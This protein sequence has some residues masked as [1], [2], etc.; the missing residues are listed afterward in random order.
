LDVHVAIEEKLFYAPLRKGAE[1][2]DEL[3]DMYEAYTEHEVARHL[4]ELLR[5]RRTPDEEFKARLQVLGESVKHHVQEEESK[6]FA[7]ARELMDPQERERIGDAWA[8]QKARMES[9][10]TG[11]KKTRAKTSSSK[12][13]TA[14]KSSAKKRR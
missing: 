3:V 10:G 12:T 6:V 5:S 7:I 4:L 8:K 9:G 1:D 13:S 14:K 2:D 11:R